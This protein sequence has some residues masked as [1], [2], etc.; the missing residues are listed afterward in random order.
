MACK[1]KH[2]NQLSAV[3]LTI[4]YVILT[5][6]SRVTEEVNNKL[7]RIWKEVVM[8]QFEVKEYLA[9]SWRIWDCSI[10]QKMVHHYPLTAPTF[11]WI[12]PYV[13]KVTTKT[14]FSQLAVPSVN[15]MP[16]VNHTGSC[17]KADTH[18]NLHRQIHQQGHSLCNKVGSVLRWTV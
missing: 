5:L 15:K 6:R 13:W 9:F 12:K 7:E 1:A 14:Q 4:L 16:E 10:L 8:A 18:T 2:R 11:K 3:S 17:C